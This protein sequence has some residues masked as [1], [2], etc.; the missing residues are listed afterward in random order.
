M[1]NFIKYCLYCML[2]VIADSSKQ[3]PKE[4]LVGLITLAIFLA[5]TLGILYLIV[6]IANKLYKK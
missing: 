1:W 3:T 2:D 5:I 6:F 4:S